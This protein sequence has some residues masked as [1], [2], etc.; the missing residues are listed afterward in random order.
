[1][2]ISNLTAPM[3]SRPA[4]ALS[5]AD[6]ALASA[7]VASLMRCHAHS[8]RFS[9]GTSGELEASLYARPPSSVVMEIARVLP[10][11][12]MSRRDRQLQ[13][14]VSQLMVRHG[15]HSVRFSSGVRGFKAVLYGQPPTPRKQH[16]VPATMA[17]TVAPAKAASDEPPVAEAPPPRPASPAISAAVSKTKVDKNALSARSGGAKREAS[18]SPTQD[19]D[20]PPTLTKRA[21][22]KPDYD[23][24]QR[25]CLLLAPQYGIDGPQV[26]DEAI[27]RSGDEELRDAHREAYGLGDHAMDSDGD[28]YSD[29]YDPG[30][31]RT[32]WG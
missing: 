10:A 11:A 31:I 23:A 25:H 2:Q 16:E 12:G 30:D 17:A 28:A 29:E 6:R 18:S 14:F 1:M 5:R 15:A 32:G 21:A 4:A 27:S 13:D 7:T 9:F 3:A 22:K 24:W 19:E 26:M 20:A 8:V